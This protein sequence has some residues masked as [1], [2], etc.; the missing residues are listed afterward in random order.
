MLCNVHST[1]ISWFSFQIALYMFM[2]TMCTLYSRLNLLLWSHI[3]RG[4]GCVGWLLI[5]VLTCQAFS[6]MEFPYCRLCWVGIACSLSDGILCVKF[7][8][9][10]L[11]HTTDTF[12]S[13]LPPG[14]AG[15]ILPRN[16]ELRPWLPLPSP[17]DSDW[18]LGL[19]SDACLSNYS[20]VDSP[21]RSVGY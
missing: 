13:R 3:S 15:E 6:S 18:W 5:S 14:T 16:T 11:L 8:L 4:G 12:Y 20:L 7:P 1:V 2:Y 21:S 10:W 9:N 17:A 19:S